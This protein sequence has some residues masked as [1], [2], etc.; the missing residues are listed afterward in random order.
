[1]MKLGSSVH[2]E[3][4]LYA[5]SGTREMSAEPLVEYFKP[6]LDWLDK[7]NKALNLT[8]GWDETSCPDGIILG[9]PNESVSNKLSVNCLNN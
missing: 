8:I 9:R 3:D 7:Q 6:L 1:M 5:I 4:A 2:W